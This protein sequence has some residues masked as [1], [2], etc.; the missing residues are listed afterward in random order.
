MTFESIDSICVV[1]S[2]Y[3]YYTCLKWFNFAI[4][5]KSF[6][7]T[8]FLR[9]FCTSWNVKKL[10]Q[11]YWLLSCVVK[12]SLPNENI[13][14]T[15][16]CCTFHESYWHVHWLENFFSTS[17]VKSTWKDF[18]SILRSVTRIVRL[19]YLCFP[20]V[21]RILSFFLALMN[22][23]GIIIFYIFLYNTLDK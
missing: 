5:I 20:L 23:Y 14:L 17:I 19:K 6:V 10:T 15:W 7:D 13:R 21:A 22:I 2:I 9:T 3:I 18:C 8:I 4:A 1:L 11:S 16:L 12:S